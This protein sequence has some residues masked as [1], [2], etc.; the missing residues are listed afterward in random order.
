MRPFSSRVIGYAAQQIPEKY[1]MGEIEMLFMAAGLDE[2]YSSAYGKLATVSN[3]V[4]TAKAAADSGDVAATEGLSELVI[5]VATK[6][7]PLYPEGELEHGTPLWELRERLL[8]DGFDLRRMFSADGYFRGV[9]IL[10]I[11]EPEI[12]PG[13]SITA[14][15]DDLARLGLTTALNHYQQAVDCYTDNRMEAANGQL[16]AMFEAVVVHFAQKNGF[17]V[18]SGHGGG[19]PAINHLINSTALPERDGGGYLRGLWQISHTNGPHPGVTTAAEV[20]HRLL[21]LTCAA[22]FLIDK[23]APP[24]P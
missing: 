7:A 20:H 8:V 13:R 22:R 11:D 6:L 5:A 4:R 16:R 3:T 15:E 12:P 18:A 23:L 21:S 9:R 24:T 19:G 14:L 2:Y 17:V 1:T 10:P